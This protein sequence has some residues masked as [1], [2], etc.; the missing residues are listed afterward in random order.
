MPRIRGDNSTS[1]VVTHWDGQK[2]E[3]MAIARVDGEPYRLLGAC[4]QTGRPVGASG[5]YQQGVDCSGDDL[6]V[7][8]GGGC[9]M[10]DSATHVSCEGMCNT[11]LGCT[12]Y[13]WTAKGCDPMSKAHNVC[14]LKG[15]ECTIRSQSTCRNYRYLGT[16][17]PSTTCPPTALQ[18]RV[19]AGPTR[20]V[21][22]LNVAD[23]VFVNMVR[24]F[25]GWPV[26]S[27][28]DHSLQ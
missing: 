12:G 23:K 1:D 2:K 11:T 27:P 5:S 10:P 8:G 18:L 20:T 16:P 4:A 14:W 17:G 9:A 3:L 28:A 26:H 24:L 21:F 6:A 25:S 15:N 7:C 19:S 13:V 22:E